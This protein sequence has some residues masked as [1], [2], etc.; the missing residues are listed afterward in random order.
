[1]EICC[2]HFAKFYILG[3]LHG[4]SSILIAPPRIE[5]DQT[6]FAAS[7]KMKDFAASPNMKEKV[8][9]FLTRAK[10]TIGK[11]KRILAYKN[12]NE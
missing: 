12:A 6:H 1:M 3:P 5:E 9:V 8:S 2:F 11:K 7:P 4:G 10:D